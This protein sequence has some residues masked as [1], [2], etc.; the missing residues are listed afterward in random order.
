M[1]LILRQMLDRPF[2]IQA[3]QIPFMGNGMGSLRLPTDPLGRPRKF[4]SKGGAVDD[5][6]LG[7]SGPS[8]PMV[9]FRDSSD[10]RA[11]VS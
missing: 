2:K 5:G 6:T 4:T 8:D 11:A 3:A 1:K 7:L 10:E 9:K